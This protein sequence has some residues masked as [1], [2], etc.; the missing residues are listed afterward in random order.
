MAAKLVVGLAGMP[1]AGKS[2]VVNVARARGYGVVVM[3]NEIREEARRRGLEPTSE[4]IGFLM[5][6]LRRLEGEAAIAKR[7]MPKILSEAKEKIIVDGVR[8]LAEVEEFRKNFKSFVLVAVHSSPETRFKRLYHRQRSDDPKNWEIFHE[9]D[10]RELSV[11]LGS[12]IAMAEYMIVNEESLDAVKR[13]AEQ[14]LER[15]EEKWMR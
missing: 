2:V 7:C 3:G 15:I 14:I 10:L 4:N 12:A 6:E 5:L 11:G 9:R 8:S 1:G 13:K